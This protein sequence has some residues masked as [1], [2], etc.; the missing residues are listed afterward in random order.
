MRLTEMHNANATLTQQPDYLVQGL[1]EANAQNESMRSMARGMPSHVTL[2]SML[3]EANVSAQNASAQR[4]ATLLQLQGAEL[5]I[6]ELDRFL[7][8]A[9]S[10]AAH[11]NRAHV[12]KELA[13]ANAIAEN[14]SLRKEVTQ[15]TQR[16]GAQHRHSETMFSQASFEEFRAK[17]EQELKTRLT[18][19]DS[20]TE[21]TTQKVRSRADAP[22]N[23]PHED[24]T[25]I[26]SH[27]HQCR[28]H[29]CTSR[30]HP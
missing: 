18:A 8:G 25:R 11:V 6:D 28:R 3:S 27:S 16:I 5:R 4:D 19:K 15:L 29:Q 12:A 10:V 7:K 9:Q 13:L 17:L 22:T 30:L 1:H 23:G 14:E 26:G 21:G 20:E 24:P 2:Q